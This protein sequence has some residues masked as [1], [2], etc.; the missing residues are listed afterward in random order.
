MGRSMATVLVVLVLGNVALAET[1]TVQKDTTLW[2]TW[3]NQ[4]SGGHKKVFAR[5][6]GTNGYPGLL[7]F[8]LSGVGYTIGTATLRMYATD[9]TSAQTVSVTP[10]VHTDN[11]AAW[12]EGTGLWSDDTSG[13]SW[14]YSSDAATATEWEDGLGGTGNVMTA[15][16][17]GGPIGSRNGTWTSQNWY[18]IALDG[19]VVE[20]RRTNGSIS[21][22]LEGDGGEWVGFVTKENVDAGFTGNIAELV[23]TEGAA[24]TPGDTDGDG[25][26]DLDDLFAVRN[27]FGTGSGAT[28]ADGDVAP[29]PNGDGAVNLDDLFI[30]RNNFGMGLIVPEPVTLWLLAVGGLTILRRRSRQ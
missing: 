3:S 20:S 13:A 25:D 23:L 24:A 11:N 28:R 27:N 17:P 30:V 4:N 9:T 12:T 29:H 26:V 15:V 19:A 1:L 7:A 10:L 16:T 18:E 6:D 14:D 21:L 5:L 2:E 8:D 22:L